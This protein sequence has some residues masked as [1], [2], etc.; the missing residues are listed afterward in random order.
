MRFAWNRATVDDPSVEPSDSE[1][2]PVAE[3]AAVDLLLADGVRRVGWIDAGGQRT[4]DWLNSG[5][6]VAVFGLAAPDE[7]P[8]D[9]PDAATAT[10]AAL[11]RGRI[12]W[13]IPPPLPPNRHLR[14]HRRRMLV[15]LELDD[16]DVSGQVHVRPG[17]DA[18]DQVMR[19]TRDLVPL[20]DVQ[21][22]SR[23]D[24]A[25]GMALPV[26]IVNR[27][28]VRRVVQDAPHVSAPVPDPV[29]TTAVGDALDPRLAWLVPVEPPAPSELP[30]E[31]AA[32]PV[33]MA[34]APSDAVD[35]SKAADP[36]EAND[37]S[38]IELLNAALALLLEAGVIDVVEFQSIR[39]RLPAPP[40]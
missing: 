19:G 11:E 26:L 27:H 40:A 36:S 9:A 3:L 8:A 38:G 34:P 39:A 31:P 28:H 32:G 17:A 30:H 22:V 29:D 23:R 12:V 21:V 25:D 2:P 37:P 4:S 35:P 13:V 14:L 10:P 5:P 33:A 15:H 18:I 6:Q 20:T 24:R 16:H 1:R 7:V